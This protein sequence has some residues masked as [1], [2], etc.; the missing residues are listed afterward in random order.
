MTSILNSEDAILELGGRRQAS[1]QLMF[2]MVEKLC[3]D[4]IINSFVLTD[5]MKKIIQ[6]DWE[7]NGTGLGKEYDNV[8]L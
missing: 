3:T 2:C 7:I 1:T 5:V 4:K 6:G 8:V